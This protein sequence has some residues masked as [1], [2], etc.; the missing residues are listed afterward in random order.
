MIQEEVASTVHRQIGLSMLRET[1]PEKREARIFD[2][3]NQLN[4]ALNQLSGPTEAS[5]L[6]QLNLEA[7][8]RAKASAAYESAFNYLKA[9]ISLL[10]EDD[11]S[12]LCDLTLNLHGEAAEA[13]YLCGQFEEMERLADLVVRNAANLFDKVRAYEVRIQG[14]IAQ[15]KKKE[16]VEIALQVLGMLGMRVPEQ[17]SKLDVLAALVRAKAALWGKKVEAIVDLPEMTNQRALTVMRV[18][19]LICST[20]YVVYPNLFPLLVLRQVELSAKHGNSP[21]SAFSYA[22]YGTILCGVLGKVEAGYRFGNLALAIQEKFHHDELK[23][24]VFFTVNSTIRHYKE[25]LRET[26]PTFREAYRTALELGDFE[27][28][29]TNAG[30]YAY[31]LFYGGND[32][33]EVSL[34]IA[35]YGEV[36]EQLQQMGY[37]RYLKLYH[38]VCLNLQADDGEPQVIKGSSYDEDVMYSDHVRIGDGHG[39]LNFHCLKILLG[40]LFRDRESA[41]RHAD[42]GRKWLFSSLGMLPHPE[43][44]FLD[45]LAR[46]V[47]CEDA[48]LSLR[49]KLLFSARKGRKTMCKGARFCPANYLHK[50]YLVEAEWSRVTGRASSAL[51]YFDLASEAARA[52]GFVHEQA[53][54]DELAGRFHLSLRNTKVARAYLADAYY[55]YSKWGA[56]A[57]AAQLETEFDQLLATA[58]AGMKS[59]AGTQSAPESSSSS[60]AN[61]DGVDMAAVLKASQIIAG[62]IHLDQLVWK[63]LKVV[64]EDAGAQKG[65][66]ILETEDKMFV[67][68]V[69]YADDRGD[70]VMI[71]VPVRQREDLAQSVVNYVLRIQEPLVLDDAEAD[72]NFSRD[73]YVSK[74]KPR[75]ILCLPLMLK[76][77][78][79]G[80]LYLE[81]N[82]ITGAFTPARVE[83]LRML[84]AQAVVSLDNAQLYRRLEENNRALR[85]AAQEKSGG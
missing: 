62:E 28:A 57:K 72:M 15:A 83:V 48:P 22:L 82:L 19:A 44:V 46:L 2:I 18:C 7:G 75:S 33:K 70:E 47:A 60:T 80:M 20:A 50:H 49:R 74:V 45:T 79:V 71:H 9:G 76:G 31:H 58:I 73:T 6:A 40:L 42:E 13:A 35:S 53:M 24:K 43:F 27:F 10:P 11:W 56:K 78:L 65:A 66:L 81:N 29:A 85:T 67:E 17:P 41:L 14:C 51:R 30:A 3:A 39:L 36:V 59:A 69:A 38:Q 8:K 64:V 32:L 26:Y 61:R 37:L 77:R 54:A 16:A 55:E 12:V 63:L 23:A 5:Q 84:A 68:G 34:E 52:S 21:L 25:H 4:A 1:P